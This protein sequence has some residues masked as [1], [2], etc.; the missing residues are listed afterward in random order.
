MTS[1]STVFQ[2]FAL[3]KVVMMI[4]ILTNI[5]NIIGNYIVIL[6]PWDFLGIG[7]AGVA[8]STLIARF[9]GAALFIICFMRFLPQ[10]RDSFENMKLEKR[11]VKSI[12]KL[13]FPSAMENVSYTTSQMIITGIIA[14][15]GSAD[16]HIKIYTQNITA[17]I[18]TLAAQFLGE[19]NYCRRY[20]G[21]RLKRKA[22][23]IQ[24]E[25]SSIR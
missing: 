1:M 11:T 25:L 12:M 3:V 24:K 10:Y 16:D 15:F 21:Y 2:S 5:I 23:I 6:S 7:I 13:G 8:N 14:T 4:S 20:I 9:I 18:F 19:S 17:I 22:K